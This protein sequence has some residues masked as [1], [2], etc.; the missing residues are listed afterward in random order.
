MES[1]FWVLIYHALH[2]LKHDYKPGALH[3]IRDMLFDTKIRETDGSVTGGHEKKT[4]MAFCFM[5]RGNS[6]LPRFKVDGLNDVL[7]Q[8]GGIFDFRYD[9]NRPEELD[10]PDQERFPALLRRTALTMEP[11]SVTP[12]GL[13]SPTNDSKPP[14]DPTEWQAANLKVGTV[15][16][17]FYRMPWSAAPA[18]MS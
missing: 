3:H 18:F 17:D 2:Y 13:V 9:S 11:L 4:V 16:M 15:K 1:A 12:T 8:L 10:D 14:A 6:K 5:G 7:E